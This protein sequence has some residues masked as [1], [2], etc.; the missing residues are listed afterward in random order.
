MKDKFWTSNICTLYEKGKYKDIFPTSSM[1]KIEQFNSLTRL[2]IISLIINFILNKESQWT[3]LSVGAIFLIIFIYNTNYENGNENEH[4]NENFTPNTNVKEILSVDNYNDNG[5]DCNEDI[6]SI[7]SSVAPSI[8]PSITTV[9][10]LPSVAPQISEI[11]STKP[12]KK[13]Q[14]LSENDT[15]NKDTPVEYNNF[16][17]YGDTV[18]YKKKELDKRLFYAFEDLWEPYVTDR[19]FMKPQDVNGIKD[20]EKFLDWVYKPGM[21]NKEKFANFV[22]GVNDSLA[23][24]IN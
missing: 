15:L 1:T 23:V 10:S 22:E 18:D 19:F 3:Y 5:D 4:E 16:A 20:R 13:P 17:V 12:I 14:K 6:D 8:A 7:I 11:S 21:T 9:H 2:A 24:D